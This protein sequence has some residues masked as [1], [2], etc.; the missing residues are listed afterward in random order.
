MVVYEKKC[1][2]SPEQSGGKVMFLHLPVILF[3]GEGSLPR[4]VSVQGGLCPGRSLS[5]G[6]LNGGS[7]SGGVLCPWGS[8]YWGSQS[9]VSVHWGSL[10]GGLCPW[11][12]SVRE[13]PCRCMVMCG[14]YTSYW[15]AFLF[16]FFFKF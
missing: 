11:G 1:C 13:T 12:V 5:S 4:G 9:G 16:F 10:L 14:Q 8:L 7:L 2:Y 15:N 3:T 6:S